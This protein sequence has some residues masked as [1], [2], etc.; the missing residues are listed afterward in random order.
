MKLRKEVKRKAEEE[1]W[2]WKDGKLICP[3]GHSNIEVMSFDNIAFYIYC[4]ECNKAI[5]DETILEKLFGEEVD[6]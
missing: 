4:K 1:G 5:E 2:K 3:N 6:R